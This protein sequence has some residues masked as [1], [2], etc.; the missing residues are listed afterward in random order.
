MVA[1]LLIITS[2]REFPRD[3][4]AT[5]GRMWSSTII[6]QNRFRDETSRVLSRYEEVGSEGSY[7]PDY[8]D[9]IKLGIDVDTLATALDCKAI[10]AEAV[11]ELV[12]MVKNSDMTPEDFDNEIDAAINP[13]SE[14]LSMADILTAAAHIPDVMEAARCHPHDQLDR[15]LH[16]QG[17]CSCFVD[18]AR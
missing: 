13:R 1:N 12:T 18:F 14:P 16:G 10:S 6:E 9:L 4:D 5:I 3:I 11:G 17:H 8:D 2:G 7:F 15:A